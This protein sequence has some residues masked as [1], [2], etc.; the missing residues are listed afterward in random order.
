MLSHRK[1][2]E[3]LETAFKGNKTTDEDEKVAVLL[4]KL[5]EKAFKTIENLAFPKKMSVITYKDA[6]G[7]LNSFYSVNVSVNRDERELLYDV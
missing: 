4:T 2:L 3:K 6:T 1:Y 7:F 5:S